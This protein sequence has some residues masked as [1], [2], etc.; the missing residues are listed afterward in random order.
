MTY[1]LF[2]LPVNLM[3][4]QLLAFYRLSGKETAFEPGIYVERYVLLHQVIPQ[5][6]RLP[7]TF[8]A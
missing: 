3:L 4:F 8:S 6:L 2:A 7:A 5:I 1:S